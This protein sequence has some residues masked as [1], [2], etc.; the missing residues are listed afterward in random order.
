[1]KKDSRTEDP[2]SSTG[3]LAV[4]AKPRTE[5]GDSKPPPTLTAYFGEK[6]I[7]A[8]AFV[9]AVKSARVRQFQEDDC[10]TA[11]ELLQKHDPEGDRLW[12]LLERRRLPEP[13]QVWVWSA[14]R[15]HLARVLGAEADI[16]DQAPERII[17]SIRRRFPALSS[18]KDKS[19]RRSFR[20]TLRI[21]ATWLLH[22]HRLPASQVIGFCCALLYRSEQSAKD[23]A[24]SAIQAGSTKEF[25]VAASVAFLERS[26]L[27][28]RRRELE[29][30]MADLANLRQRLDREID[31]GSELALRTGELDKHNA[32]LMRAI[33]DLR[34]QL[35]GERQH[36]GYDFSAL[37][38][39]N[40]VFLRECLFPLIQDAIDALE[41]E[42]PV[43]DIAVRRLKKAVFTIERALE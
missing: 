28:A 16:T 4:V 25:D 30:A 8:T 32:E 41:I 6:K 12:A 10:A 11:L 35:Q 27:E 42:T 36:S 24:A 29:K 23:A 40:A 15:S 1:M 38:T 33:S 22:K 21:V 34:E 9:K 2:S 7:A 17:Q 43:P 19:E 37:K 39:R 20:R 3:S 5:R 14:A 26:I 31:R 18:S 13:L